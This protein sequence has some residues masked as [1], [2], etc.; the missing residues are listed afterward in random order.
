MDFGDLGRLASVLPDGKQWVSIDARRAAG[1]VGTDFGGLADQARAQ[2]P[3]QGLEYL[4]GLSGDVEKLGDDTVGGRA[5]HALPRR[6]STTPRSP[7]QLPSTD[8]EAAPTSWR[9][10]ATVPADVWID[11]DDRVVKMHMKIDDER[12]R[13]G[14]SGRSSHDGDHRL[15]RAGRRAGA[16][17]RR[18]RRLSVV[19][20][21]ST[22]L[23]D[24]RGAPVV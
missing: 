19:V 17:G 22:G 21:C 15:R 20:R 24:S 10:S 23:I 12:A 4:Q 5:R 6:R 9:S 1:A 7:T 2:R 14:A 18:G 3:E 13:R 8:A 16:A 11:D